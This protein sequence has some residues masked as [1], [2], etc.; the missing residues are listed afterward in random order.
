MDILIDALLDSLKLIPFLF[1]T[2]LFL[3]L[4]EHKANGKL[5][6]KIQSSK[7]YGPVLGSIFGLFPQCGFSSAASSLYVTKII[8]L[9]TLISVY[10]ATSDEM[11]PVLL[12]NN[13]GFTV[14]FQILLIKLFV[15]IIVGMIID[16]I[17]P[18][19]K[20]EHIEIDNFCEN[21]HCHCDHG[22]VRS[23]INHTIRISFYIFIVTIILNLLLS[24]NI[25]TNFSSTNPIVS[26]IL[27]SLIG[28]IPNCASSVALT[29]LYVNGLIPFASLI[30]GLLTNAGVG[31][32]VLFRLN[33]NIKEN[34]S[35][36][37]ILLTSA[38]IVGLLFLTF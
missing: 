37:A 34:I 32:L 35:I 30:S 8:T 29:E 28:L 25:I 12:A 6:Q 36:I 9:G 5:L 23:A 19:F 31:L 4:L 16:Y 24:N 11:I 7:K 2:Y 26:I 18:I 21:E 38:I 20:K 15:G 3:E 1:V 13:I 17:N 27:S 10:L 14:I 22:V 33:K